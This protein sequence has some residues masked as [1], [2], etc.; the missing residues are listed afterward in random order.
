MS[1]YPERR[2]GRLTGVWI[3][4]APLHPG[5]R[6]IRRRF[7]TQKEGQQWADLVRLTGTVPAS[8]DKPAGGN[9]TTL[10][11]VAA[12][13][14]A[15]GGPGGKWKR[16]RDKQVGQRIDY[17]VA[18]L[19]PETPIGAITTASLDKLVAGLA[20]RPGVSGKLTSGSINRYLAFASALLKFAVDHGHLVA[21]PKVPWQHEGGRRLLWLSWDDEAA[22]CSA[23][24]SRGMDDA[25]L[26]VTVLCATG[27][28][29]GELASLEPSQV[30]DD[31]VRL[32]VTKTDRA[33]SIPIAPSLARQ[34]RELVARKGVP[35]HSTM[36]NNFKKAVISAGRNSKL[37]IHSCRHTTASRL[38]QGGRNLKIVKDFL[39]HSSINTTL[40]YAHI[41]EETLVEAA[42]ILT[43][44]AGESELKAP[45]RL[46]HNTEK[47]GT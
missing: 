23:L 7:A 34:L 35:P 22:I 1:C 27:M 20:K 16:R 17:V 21:S 13:C 36:G 40:K 28:R 10:G 18:F 15:A 26:V 43:P 5:E 11:M 19:G 24:R 31:W 42:K 12:E 6:P 29:W 25:A 39:G 4:E 44:P 8:T 9:V 2:K 37:C 47:S 30:E 38:V 45:F 32:W 41:N 46:V 33:R 14:K 3:A